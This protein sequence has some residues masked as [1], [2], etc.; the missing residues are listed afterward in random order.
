MK[1]SN[2]LR[3][4]SE[5][6]YIHRFTPLKIYNGTPSREAEASQYIFKG[7]VTDK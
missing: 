6:L 4:Y 7:N 1:N 2:N 3:N 5:N